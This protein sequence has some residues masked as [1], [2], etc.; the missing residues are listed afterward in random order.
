MKAANRRRS[1]NHSRSN[2][3]ELIGLADDEGAEGSESPPRGV[4]SGQADAK[5]N[6]PRLSGL[7]F[8]VVVL[9]EAPDARSTSVKDIAAPGQSHEFGLD[10]MFVFQGADQCG[11]Q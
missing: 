7:H 1:S 2:H 6:R 9:G 8:P 10:L 5:V 11:L 3:A 4:D